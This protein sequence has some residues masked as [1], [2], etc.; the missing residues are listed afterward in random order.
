MKGIAIAALV[1][2][3]GTSAPVAKQRTSPPGADVCPEP[4][5]TIDVLGN[6]RVRIQREPLAV[7]RE[8]GVSDEQFVALARQLYTVWNDAHPTPPVVAVT[9]P[10]RPVAVPHVE[11]D[12]DKRWWC[13]T[14]DDV[15]WCEETRGACEEHLTKTLHCD[16]ETDRTMRDTCVSVGI[17]V[18]SI[19]KCERQARAAC[20]AKYMK[21]Y[22]TTQLGCAPTMESCKDR[23]AN[24]IKTMKD[25]IKV[26]SECKATE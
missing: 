24:A 19:R 21:L 6:L 25:D 22:D 14:A 13:Y 7:L 23:R 9:P 3:C 17:Q 15:G 8:L 11:S 2:A 10:A 20:F 18:H 1:A 5:P 12:D 26:T 16:A 4:P